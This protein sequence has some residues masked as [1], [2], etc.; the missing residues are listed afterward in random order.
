M[1]DY[2]LDQ[3]GR[4]SMKDL[5]RCV[6]GNVWFGFSDIYL[7]AWYFWRLLAN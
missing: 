5:Q 7:K 3:N 4:G 1:K 2:S 6:P